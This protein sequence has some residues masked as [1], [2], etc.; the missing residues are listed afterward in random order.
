MEQSFK[1]DR[2][3]ARVKGPARDGATGYEFGLSPKELPHLFTA[4]T[5]TNVKP[6]G[7]EKGAGLGLAIA[8]KIVEAHEGE[9]AVTSVRGAGTSFLFTLPLRCG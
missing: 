8:K 2:V 4:F 7:G 1:A 9:I 3:D 5:K 6:V